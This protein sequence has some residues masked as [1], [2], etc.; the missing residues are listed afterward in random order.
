MKTANNFDELRA[1]MLQKLVVI[2]RTEI[3]T[4]IQEHQRLRIQTDVYDYYDRI[5]G[6]YNPK[7]DGSHYRRT[8]ELKD[9]INISNINNGAVVANDSHDENIL[10]I[11][12]S[13][14]GYNWRNSMIAQLQ[15]PR[16]FFSNTIDDI[17]RG[18]LDGDIARILS[19]HGIS[20]GVM[21][22]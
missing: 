20:G 12:E 19:S 11:V 4:L 5:R 16:P 1:M 7:P 21:R 17:N 9:N 3:A 8:Y 14:Q 13:G 10:Q 2:I 6:G 18:L 15:L 22:N